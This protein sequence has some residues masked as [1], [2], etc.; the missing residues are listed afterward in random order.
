VA[1]VSGNF[2]KTGFIRGVV[3]YSHKYGILLHIKYNYEFLNSP[4]F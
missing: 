2:P 4:V 3:L 1:N